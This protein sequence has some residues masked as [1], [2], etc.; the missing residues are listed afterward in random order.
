VMSTTGSTWNGFTLNDLRA[1]RQ[2]YPVE[3]VASA[4]GSVNAS[5]YPEFGWTSVSLAGSYEVF[6]TEYRYEYLMDDWNGD[7]VYG[8]NSYPGGTW[9]TTGTTFTSPYLDGADQ[10]T[11]TRVYGVRPIYPN[12]RP[13]TEIGMGD[14]YGC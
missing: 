8:W 3:S 9:Y 6:A 4:T 7:P 14:I 2:M 11:C 5:G 12:G 10:S 1:A 13:G